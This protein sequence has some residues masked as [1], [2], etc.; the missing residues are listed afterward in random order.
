MSGL[1]L[2]LEEDGRRVSEGAQSFEGDGLQPVRKS[3]VRVGALAP[4]GILLSA[5]ETLTTND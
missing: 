3:E 2:H 1:I 4:E 5:H